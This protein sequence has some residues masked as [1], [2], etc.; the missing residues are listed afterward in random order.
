MIIAIERLLY[1][2]K[3]YIGLKQMEFKMIIGVDDVVLSNNWN[4]KIVDSFGLVWFADFL[5][6]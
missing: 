5:P 4:L 3:Y 2:M 1:Q 6:V